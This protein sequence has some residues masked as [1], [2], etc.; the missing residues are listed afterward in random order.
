M[1]AA[2]TDE[3]I[4]YDSSVSWFKSLFKFSI[5]QLLTQH[6]TF[7]KDVLRCIGRKHVGSEQTLIVALVFS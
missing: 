1:I 7:T 4:K 6:N 5:F 2:E 3:H